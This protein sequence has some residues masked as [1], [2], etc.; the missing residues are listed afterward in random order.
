MPPR[1]A[2]DLLFRHLHAQAVQR[3]PHE[4]RA[5][6]L[7]D[8]AHAARIDA[9][10]FTLAHDDGS[11]PE[12]WGQADLLLVGVSAGSLASAGRPRASIE[13]LPQT[14]QLDVV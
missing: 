10:N 2:S 9:I 1:A 4:R 3:C 8:P 12:D 6:Q 11:Y 7:L 5:L 14:P 13:A